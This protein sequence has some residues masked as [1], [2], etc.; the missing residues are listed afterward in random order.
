MS[1][2][3]TAKSAALRHFSDSMGP[4]ERF[5]DNIKELRQTSPPPAPT[6]ERLRASKAKTLYSIMDSALDH[7]R[8]A[9][10]ELNEFV[11]DTEETPELVISFSETYEGRGL[12]F[13]LGKNMMIRKLGWKGNTIALKRAVE[14][15]IIY[16]RDHN[17]CRDMTLPYSKSESGEAIPLRVVYEQTKPRRPS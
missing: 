1:I 2:R 3:R 13:K 17:V 10:F 9:E 15:A 14:D 4:N 11:E 5:A 8:L 16:L 7:L 6:S 12:I